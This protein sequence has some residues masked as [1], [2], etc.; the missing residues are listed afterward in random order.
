M[1]RQH[2]AKRTVIAVL[3]TV[4]V[5]GLMLALADFAPSLNAA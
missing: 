2:L 3:A 1:Q 5:A 4:V